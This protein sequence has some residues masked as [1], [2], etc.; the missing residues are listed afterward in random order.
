M[1]KK[2]PKARPKRGPKKPA[3]VETLHAPR[4]P[5]SRDLPPKTGAML[6]HEQRVRHIM[7]LMRSWRWVRGESGPELATLWGASIHTVNKDADEAHRRVVGEVVDP[8]VVKED[9]CVALRHVLSEAIKN[10]RDGYTVDNGERVYRESP[11]G[12]QRV[13]I[14]AAKVWSGIVGAKAAEK[15]ELTGDVTLEAIDEARRVAEANVA[16]IPERESGR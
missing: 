4:V 7:A 3:A 2:K 15:I 14:E 16:P 9:L 13:V 11:I 8:L 5:L 6:D 10:A 1:A 12:S